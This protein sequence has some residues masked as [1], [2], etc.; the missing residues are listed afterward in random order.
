MQLSGS[1]LRVIEQVLQEGEQKPADAVLRSTLRSS[2]LRPEQK[3]LI[4]RSVFL[5][6]RW[7]GWLDQAQPLRGQLEYA[8]EL[9]G[10][11]PSIPDEDLAAR[12]LPAWAKEACDLSPALLRELQGEPR[13]WLRARPG[14]SSDLAVKLGDCQP[15]RTIPDALWYRG[16][17]DLFRT[18]AFHSGDFEIQDLSSQLVGHLCAPSPGD[19]WWDACAGEGGKTLHLCDLMENRGLVWASDTA[20]WRLEQLKRRASRARLFN[21]RLKAWTAK[22]Q[23]PTK[24]KFNGI[25]VD[26]PCSGVG[27]WGRN[28]HAR[29]KLAPTDVTELATLQLEIL[30][31]VAGSLKPRGMLIYSV[32]TLTRA[33][34]TAVA[35]AFARAH[36]EF[37]RLPLSLPGMNTAESGQVFLRPEEWHAGGMFVAGFVLEPSKA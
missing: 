32:C 28:P 34:T 11:L 27:T 2:L 19:T 26:A 25:L 16:D 29:W 33:E 12:A 6:Y 4:S 9:A 3:R 5:Y 15:H 35:E 14:T 13:L 20:Q 31:K 37:Q 8:D 36:P 23:L 1:V 10:Q 17:E 7:L 30:N 18:V 21:Y 24:A 22:D